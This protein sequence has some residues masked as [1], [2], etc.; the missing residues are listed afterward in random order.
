MGHFFSQNLV[1]L[2]Y[3]GLNPGKYFMCL[4]LDSGKIN[5]F[6]KSECAFTLVSI[7]QGLGLCRS[8]ALNH[9]LCRAKQ[10]ELCCFCLPKRGLCRCICYLSQTKKGRALHQHFNSTRV[11][12]TPHTTQRSKL[13]IISFMLILYVILQQQ[14]QRLRAQLQRLLF[15]KK[16]HSF[17]TRVAIFH[18]QIKLHCNVFF[19]ADFTLTWS[20]WWRSVS[21][22]PGY[23]WCSIFPLCLTRWGVQ[24]C[25]GRL[26]NC[27]KN[28]EEGRK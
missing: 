16:C 19:P 13:L 2:G 9:H 26:W 17:I 3:L 12:L 5:C 7:D 14:Q 25:L 24:A 15:V 4:T 28:E 6:W 8:E 11:E 20:D 21:H 1:L 22:M 18:S 27:V 10:G 23:L